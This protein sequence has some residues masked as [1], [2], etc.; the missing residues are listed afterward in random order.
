MQC[1]RALRALRPFRDWGDLVT[2]VTGLRA[3]QP[4]VLASMGGL[5]VDGQPLPSAA[6]PAGY[7]S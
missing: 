6:P 1:A 2:Q 7:L 3:A 4:A 5:T